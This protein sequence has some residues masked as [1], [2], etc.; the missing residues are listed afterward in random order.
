MLFEFGAT[1]DEIWPL[2]VIITIF[3][4]VFLTR[5]PWTTELGSDF[6][7]QLWFQQQFRQT[8]KWIQ[9]NYLDSIINE[10]GTFYP[11]FPSSLLARIPLRWMVPV[12]IIMNFTF[13]AVL[14]LCVYALLR[15][16]HIDPVTSL[17]GA[18]LWACLPIL[19]P[20]NARLIGLGARTLGSLL[21]FLWALGAYVFIQGNWF[22]GFCVM[23]LIS[24]AIIMSSQMAL[25]N[26]LLQSTIISIAYLNPFPLL[27]VLGGLIIAA[28]M[29]MRDSLL[30]KLVHIR[31][32]IAY[33]RK[34]IALRNNFRYL[35]SIINK[36]PLQVFPYVFSST[37]PGILFVGFIGLTPFIIFM[38]SFQGA[39]EL[40]PLLFFCLIV[41]TGA[42]IAAIL[43][44]KGPLEVFGE[45]ERYLE[46]TSPFL[47]IAALLYLKNINLTEPLLLG[48]VLCLCGIFINQTLFKI[49]S[50]SKT[51]TQ[52]ISF[53]DVEEVSKILK[54]LGR[55]RIATSP[56]SLASKLSI[57]LSDLNKHHFLHVLLLGK[58]NGEYPW[59]TNIGKYP[60]LDTRPEFLN[61]YE[62]D[63]VIIQR[64]HLKDLPEETN[65]KQLESWKRWSTDS[66][67]IFT[68]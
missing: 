23:L 20:V 56:I 31:W 41:S 48:L 42:M 39:N 19:H 65:T 40:T 8:K 52:S 61:F 58:V 1:G 13:D 44:I 38:F 62:I 43:T 3:F 47:I 49:S 34:F 35:I 67:E 30:L 24:I 59:P 54:P 6:Y 60:Y 66:F 27:C 37:T 5:L 10:A 51:I 26:I 28:N 7:T 57:G 68:R 55:R 11:P 32:Y 36:K 21:Y 16:Q 22:S 25:Q 33:G 12:G 53:D 9:P 17:L 4:L 46:Y 64:S 2:I 14:A 18:S 15:S 63:T 45:S 29:G 50:I